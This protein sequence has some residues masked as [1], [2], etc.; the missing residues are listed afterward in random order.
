MGCLHLRCGKHEY[1]FP[2]RP[3]VRFKEVEKFSRPHA[4][5]L[6]KRFRRICT[7]AKVPD[8]RIRDLRHFATTMLFIEGVADAIIRKMTGHRSEELERYKH[9]SLALKQQ[10]VELIAG[11]LSRQL[12]TNLSPASK[13]AKGRSEERP[14]VPHLRGFNGGADG[15][16]SARRTD[17][18]RLGFSLNEINNLP[19]LSTT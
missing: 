4:W 2:A 17:P 19:L 13:N 6:G 11:R 14:D 9:L 8:L 18:D 5:D 16:R 15:T 3:N 7:K 1:L 12:S 10:T